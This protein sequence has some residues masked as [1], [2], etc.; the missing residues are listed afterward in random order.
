MPADIPASQAGSAIRRNGHLRSPEV[1]PTNDQALVSA[2]T[3]QISDGFG[4]ERHSGDLLEA[5]HGQ[6]AKAATAS[7][8][9]DRGYRERMRTLSDGLASAQLQL[10]TL[11]AS[12]DKDRGEA[13]KTRFDLT[14]QVVRLQAQLKR[15]GEGVEKERAE[16]EA[17]LLNLSNALSGVDVQLTQSAGM[18]PSRQ[19]SRALR[20]AQEEFRRDQRRVKLLLDK[21]KHRYDTSSRIVEEEAQRMKRKTEELAG[22]RAALAES[23]SKESQ[24]K[25]NVAAL[26]SRVANLDKQ[27]RNARTVL[28]REQELR[29]KT[30]AALTSSEKQRKDETKNLWSELAA[31]REVVTTTRQ[32]YEGTVKQREDLRKAIQQEKRAKNEAIERADVTESALQDEIKK[33]RRAAEQREREVAELKKQIVRISRNVVLSEEK[34]AA[35]TQILGDKIDKLNQETLEAQAAE[36]KNLAARTVTRVSR[37]AFRNASQVSQTLA[38]QGVLNKLGETINTHFRNTTS[39][40]GGAKASATTLKGSG[41]VSV[42]ATKNDAE[43]E[44]NGTRVF[45]PKSLTNL[46]GEMRRGRGRRTSPAVS[47]SSSPSLSERAVKGVLGGVFSSRNTAT[48][49]RGGGG[50]GGDVQATAAERAGP[51]DGGSVAARSAVKKGD[52]RAQKLYQGGGS[53]ETEMTPVGPSATAKSDGDRSGGLLGRFGRPSQGSGRRKSPLPVATTGTAKEPQPDRNDGDGTTNDKADRERRRVSANKVG[54][55]RGVSAA[56]VTAGVA[57]KSSTP[58]VAS[59]AA[60]SARPKVDQRLPPATATGSATEALSKPST[61]GGEALR[62]TEKA[63]C[64]DSRRHRRSRDEA[65]AERHR[66]GVEV[67]AGPSNDD[68]GNGMEKIRAPWASLKIGGG[69]RPRGE[70][71]SGGKVGTDSADKSGGNARVTRMMGLF[72]GQ[73]DG[74]QGRSESHGNVPDALDEIGLGG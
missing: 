3:G 8:E 49:G 73:Q 25:H 40:A 65:N 56:R 48:E 20:K 24:L 31:T 52:V 68:R 54:S 39:S 13:A 33:N 69:S 50:G 42:N 23:E 9:T 59:T 53:R 19:T 12:S 26:G 61:P 16:M 27:L 44:P 18:T 62:A 57:S 36:S 30:Q 38:P 10:A 55:N 41:G 21:Q 74:V 72:R 17:V 28:S 47:S 67:M 70:R 60:P 32:V 1:N 4:T 5:R 15:A 58:A 63:A 11:K 34:R 43:D 66:P 14:M 37:R 22:L 64:P 46:V 45:S 35:E 29:Y 2:R 51:A 7:R 6:R 71:G